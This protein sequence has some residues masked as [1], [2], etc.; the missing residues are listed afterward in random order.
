MSEWDVSSVKDM[1]V[2]FLS[3]LSLNGDIPKWDVSKLTNMDHIFM[4]I[5]FI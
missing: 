3:V 2:I 4:R 1:S 5:S